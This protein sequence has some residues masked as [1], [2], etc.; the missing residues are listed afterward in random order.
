MPATLQDAVTVC[1]GLDVSFLW[2]DSLRIVQDD[3]K[4][5]RRELSHMA[6]IYELALVVISASRA[7]SVREGFLQDTPM[8]YPRSTC[9]PN[10]L[11]LE[12]TTGVQSNV[13][14]FGSGPGMKAGGFGSYSDLENTR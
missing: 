11:R 2:I 5:M 12:D 14:L 7:A 13:I 8:R 10:R 3:E 4:D 1:R 6:Q 9:P